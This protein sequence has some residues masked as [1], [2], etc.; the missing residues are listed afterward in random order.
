MFKH[1]ITQR[2]RYGETD[3]MGYV[4]Y[5]NYAL[6]YE[7]GRVEALR[8]LG[9]T[10][11]E[12][13]ENGIIMPV[14]RVEAKYIQPAK[15]DDLIEITTVIKEMP[16]R[17]IT[18]EVLIKNEEKH[19]LHKAKVTLGF[20]DINKNKPITTPPVIINCLKPFLD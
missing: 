1:S 3:Q 18:F 20:M 7:V 16:H 17:F 5:G 10:Y 8:T 12:L 11:R 4:Y 14:V 9:L 6:Y 19:I 13:E 2:V 15:Y